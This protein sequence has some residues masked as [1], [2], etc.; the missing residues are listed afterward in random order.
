M[1]HLALD[2]SG[3]KPANQEPT[4]LM[5]SC[6][7][8]QIIARNPKVSLFQDAIDRGSN[9][10]VVVGGDEEPDSDAVGDEEEEKQTAVG[11]QMT[12]NSVYQS[13][14]VRSLSKASNGRVDRSTTNTNSTVSMRLRSQQ[15]S[16]Y[17]SP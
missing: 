6:N 5:Q 13:G 2:L 11:P 14:H 7:S 16:Q 15:Q 10:K 3:Y 4:P 9:R 17:Q 12:V 8:Q 1:R